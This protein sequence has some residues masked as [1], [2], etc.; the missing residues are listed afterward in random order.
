MKKYTRYYTTI[1][2]KDALGIL[3]HSIFPFQSSDSMSST[4]SSPSTPGTPCTPPLDPYEIEV[5]QKDD[6]E[7]VLDFLRRFFIR[8]EPLNVA[9]KLLDNDES[10]CAELEEYSLKELDNGFNLKAVSNGKIIGVS[11]NG[12]LERGYINEL[13]EV[14]CPNKKFEKVL[15]LLD[16]VAKESDVF[17]HFPDVD[18]AMCVKI[19][20]V[21]GKWRGRGIAKDLMNR[22]R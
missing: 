2:T 12:I 20:S 11:L 22:T 6:K 10:R 18:K 7:E 17:S 8:D 13:A 16:H 14:S 9:V 19:L 5:I 1:I 21:D 15:M 4:L 3:L